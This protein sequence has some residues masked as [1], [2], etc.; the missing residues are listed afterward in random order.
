MQ[1]RVHSTQYQA[2][3]VCVDTY[4]N[5]VLS[6][7]FYNPH[8]KDG[9]V[10]QSL[11]QFLKKVAQDLDNLNLPQSFTQARTFAPGEKMVCRKAP[12][13]KVQQGAMA[14]FALQVRFRQNTSWQGSILWVE[15]K[16]EYTFRSVLE[17][18]LLMDSALCQVRQEAKQE[19]Q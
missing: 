8:K 6:G 16:L 5:D 2:I 11:T 17:L 12:Q 13:G 14:T 18:I 3:M 19:S 7:R 4:E 1:T 9:I 15:E 10:F